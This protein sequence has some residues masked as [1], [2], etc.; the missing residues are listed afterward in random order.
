MSESEPF[1]DASLIHKALS[2]LESFRR[3]R[4]SQDETCLRT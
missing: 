4:I 1:D 2:K 3:S